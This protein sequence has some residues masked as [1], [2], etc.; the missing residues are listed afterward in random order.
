[1]EVGGAQRQVLNLFRA[2]DRRRFDL[3]LVCLGR[4][5]EFGKALQDEGFPAVELHK[6]RA[7]DLTM[8]RR[9]LAVL[10]Q[11]RP[12]I[13]HCTI[14][15]ANLWGRMAALLAGVPVRIAHEQ[16]TVSLE[17]W[18]RRLVDRLLAPLTWR[19]LVV[20]D[21]L[22][23]RVADEEGIAPSRIEV[24]HNAIDVEAIRR[25]ADAPQPALP[26]HSPRIG[27]V[28]RIEYRKDHLTMVRAAAIL[29]RRAPRAHCLLA[30]DGPDR[31]L[32]EAEIARLGLQDRFH[33]LGER[34]DI[35]VLLHS[36]DVYVLCST[37][38]GLSLS[39]LEAMAAAR[40]VVA[41]RVGGNPE[42]LDQGR[43]GVL[44]PPGDPDALAQAVADLLDDP[45][46]AQALAHAASL[47]AEQF[48]IRAVAANLE[49]LYER[50]AT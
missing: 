28:G 20:S 6:R 39:I 1:M 42:L 46:R 34:D 22:R 38:E 32:I 18:H 7:L 8:M 49:A 23:R 27:L 48:D 40:P 9:L 4:L 16:S 47:R 10:R 17:K 5:G 30:G 37:T 26:G 19:V 14:Y 15:T 45:A 2:I 41:T 11:W 44:V 43:A 35:A 31:P 50:A 25:A 13:V 21:D 36:F 33:L 3:R 12:Q 29:A 24:L